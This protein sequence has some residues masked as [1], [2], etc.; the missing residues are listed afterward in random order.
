MA[1]P[2]TAT[3]FT[4]ILHNISVKV[5]QGQ[6]GAHIGAE[7]LWL[8]TVGGEGIYVQGRGM[9]WNVAE[10]AVRALQNYVAVRKDYRA[11]PNVGVV[12]G[13]VVGKVALGGPQP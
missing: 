7:W 2:N 3:L 13:T 12:G 5:S 4:A 8:G 1:P 6:G 9:T 11:V 10:T